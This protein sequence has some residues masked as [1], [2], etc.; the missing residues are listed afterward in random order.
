MFRR[1]GARVGYSG[2]DCRISL[3]SSDG[4]SPTINAANENLTSYFDGKYYV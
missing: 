4:Y 3:R 2:M 1:E